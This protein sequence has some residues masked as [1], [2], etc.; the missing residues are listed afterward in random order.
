MQLYSER[1]MHR[2]NP[3]QSIMVQQTIDKQFH[4]DLN[5]EDE[6]GV[7]VRTHIHIEA[8]VID[9]IRARVPYP[10]DLP[11]LQ[12][13]ARLRLAVALGMKQEYLEGLRL[14]GSIRNSFSHNLNATLSEDKTNELF[15]KLGSE[16]QEL[17][18]KA[19][20]MT[21]QQLGV[22]DPPPFTE[23]SPK[24]RFILIAVVLK[25]YVVAAAHE[26]TTRKC[27]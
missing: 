16:G 3:P 14:V 1:I 7:V 5:A 17:T 24:D 6:L 2:N 11:K 8:S 20:A 12:Y 18:H 26:A 4:R 27:I 21:N 19:Y 10:D 9:F 15:S 13:E 22:K 23:L 25:T